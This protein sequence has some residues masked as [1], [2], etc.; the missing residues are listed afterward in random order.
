[1]IRPSSLSGS[2]AGSP[3]GRVLQ[4]SLSLKDTAR[5]AQCTCLIRAAEPRA[6]KQYPVRSI[7]STLGNRLYSYLTFRQTSD[8]PVKAT[9]RTIL[10]AKAVWQGRAWSYDGRLPAVSC[11]RRRRLAVRFWHRRRLR[12][13]RVDLK[14]TFL[15]RP[16]SSVQP[17]PQL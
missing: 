9:A 16:R 2:R 12:P 15:N 5:I 4:I 3:A 6:Q 11:T 1:M 13:V 17:S 14:N 10:S 8:V 7:P